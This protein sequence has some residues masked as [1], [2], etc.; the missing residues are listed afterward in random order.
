M[1]GLGTMVT[2]PDGYAVIVENRRHIVGMYLLDVEGNDPRLV[3]Q[4]AVAAIEF[5]IRQLP[6]LRQSIVDQV[7][8]NGLN[9]VEGD[10]LKVVN[11]RRKASCTTDILGAS[12]ELSRQFG[13]GGF[14]FLHVLL[15][16]KS[17]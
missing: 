4:L 10:A 12:L 5:D 2:S 11:S 6:E 1:E 14:L 9:A 15:S 8:F 7:L 13:P 17:L 16:W 3:I